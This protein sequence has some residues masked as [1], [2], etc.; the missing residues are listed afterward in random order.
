MLACVLLSIG[1]ASAQNTKTYTGFV[2]DKN[3]NPVVGA[4]V[5]APGG[6]ASTITDSDGSFKIEV[7]VLLKKLTASYT[8]MSDKTLKLGE[9][10]KL[11]FKM[12]NLKKMTGFISVVGNIGINN[13]KEVD[14]N[15]YNDNYY[16][17]SFGGG[18]MGGQMG[19]LG[20]WGWYVKGM[21]YTDS[22]LYGTG[23]LTG[24]VIRKLSKKSHIYLGVGGAYSDYTG[25]PGFS[26]D[27]GTMFNV[28]DRI[29]IIA[30]LNY[31]NCVNRADYDEYG[32]K[33]ISNHINLNIGVGYT[34]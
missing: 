29:N 6:G 21:V 10:S 26:I 11:V 17:A 33:E 15:S 4:E 28:S 23:S 32:F 20:N 30:G 1:T 9:S 22:D 14:D 3:G 5:M 16:S 24:G 13:N 25:T 8:G 2:V 34:F 12:R 7:P 31:I 19:Q 27:L 18:I